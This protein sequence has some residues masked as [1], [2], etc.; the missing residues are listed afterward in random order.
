MIRSQKYDTFNSQSRSITSKGFKMYSTVR[1]AL[2]V[3]GIKGTTFKNLMEKTQLS[4]DELYQ[5]IGQGFT[6]GGIEGY[7]VNG[8]MHYR[9]RLRDKEVFKRQYFSSR[10]R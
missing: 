3:F 5:I 9:N 1:E 2:E 8:V 4:Q 7:K 10:K 6:N